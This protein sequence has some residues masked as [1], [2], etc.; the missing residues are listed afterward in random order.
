MSSYASYANF[1][2]ELQIIADQPDHMF[3]GMDS[4]PNLIEAIGICNERPPP[5]PE[6]AFVLNPARK[7][8]FV[9]KSDDNTFQKPD[10]VKG[11]PKC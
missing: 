5:P 7:I 1:R 3:I 8:L 11:I 10:S 6:D 9:D 2:A 4:A